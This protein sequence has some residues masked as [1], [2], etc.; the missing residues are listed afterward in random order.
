VTA[1]TLTGDVRYLKSAFRSEM[2]LLLD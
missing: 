2:T 1:V